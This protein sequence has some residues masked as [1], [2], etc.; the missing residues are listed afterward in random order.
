MNADNTE[1]FKFRLE[2][3]EGEVEVEGEIYGESHI[4]FLDDIKFKAVIGLLN[5]IDK[6]NFSDSG[7]HQVFKYFVREIE[8]TIHEMKKNDQFQGKLN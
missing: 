4:P 7:N 3:D 6:K 8:E 1:K 5:S 2:N